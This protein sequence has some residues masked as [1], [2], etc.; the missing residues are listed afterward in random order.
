MSRLSDLYALQETDSELADRRSVLEQ[1][2]AQLG[3]SEGLAG[4]RADLAAEQ[5]RLTE[6]AA[7]QRDLDLQVQERRE[8]LGNVDAK[9]Y[10]GTVENPRE[11]VA[12]QDDVEQLRGALRQVEER[13]LAVM[14]AIE[15][16]QNRV[17]G[18]TAAL[19]AAEQAWKDQQG[20]LTSQQTTLT[21]Q[22]AAA[23]TRRT[24]AALPVS[25]ADLALYQTLLQMKLGRAVARA[26]RGMCLACR[27]NQPL[28]IVQRARSGQ[29]IVQCTSCQRILFAG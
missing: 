21:A 6:L 4:R 24:A 19:E 2:E 13:L 5:A 15:E 28:S 1:V 17:Q 18:E 12:L 14:T 10:S 8:H 25:P 27:I 7:E 26:E 11:L 20:R 23:T 3:E 22:V 29:E 9:L 16:I